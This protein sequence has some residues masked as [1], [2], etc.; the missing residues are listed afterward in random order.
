M[1]F[2]AGSD[3][4]ST[5]EQQAAERGVC[6]SFEA[7]CRNNEGRY[8]VPST[9]CRVSTI[10]KSLADS[11]PRLPQTGDRPATFALTSFSA[12]GARQLVSAEEAAGGARAAGVGT[13]TRYNGCEPGGPPQYCLAYDR[14]PRGSLLR[15]LPMTRPTAQAVTRNRGALVGVV[16]C[17]DDARMLRASARFRSFTRMQC[18][19]AES[20]PDLDGYPKRSVRVGAQ[21]SPGRPLEQCCAVGEELTE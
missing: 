13:A 10:F 21:K 8:R 20:L 12:G 18:G 15:I 19:A 17:L 11:R 7:P 5:A 1:P 6:W 2:T 4:W 9:H 14:L 3:F 16:C